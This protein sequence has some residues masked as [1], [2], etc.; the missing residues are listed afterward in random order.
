MSSCRQKKKMS[1]MCDEAAAVCTNIWLKLSFLLL[2]R[3][4]VLIDKICL[5]P[6][7]D[8]RQSDTHKVHDCVKERELVGGWG[9][10]YWL[11]C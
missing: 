8:I 2:K 4:P 7:Y 6:W 5:Q 3:P 11:F 9:P 10:Q 1:P